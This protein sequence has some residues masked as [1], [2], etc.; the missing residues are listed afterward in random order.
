[1]SYSPASQ[2]VPTKF[3][4]RTFNFKKKDQCG[5]EVGYLLENKCNFVF[6]TL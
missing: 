1:M 3:I 2:F 5:L 6:I 4:F